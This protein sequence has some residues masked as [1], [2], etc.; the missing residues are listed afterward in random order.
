[1]GRLLIRRFEGKPLK[2]MGLFWGGEGEV[3]LK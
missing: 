3:Y 1:M 2:K